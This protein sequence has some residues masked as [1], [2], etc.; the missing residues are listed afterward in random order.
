MSGRAAGAQKLLQLQ[1]IE[2]DFS[3]LVPQDPVALYELTNFLA[4][5]EPIL[6]TRKPSTAAE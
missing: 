5:R 1:Q 3:R 2:S 6:I 4:G